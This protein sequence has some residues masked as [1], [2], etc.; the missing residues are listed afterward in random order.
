MIFKIKN[1]GNTCYFNT[2]L[3]AFLCL[4]SVREYIQGVNLIDDDKNDKKL[5]FALSDM[6][7]KY[8]KQTR[9]DVRKLYK[10]YVNTFDNINVNEPE[11]CN[12]CLLR[13][14]DIFMSENENNE[15]MKSMFYGK[16]REK[17]TYKCCNH[18]EYIDEP[19]V[20]LM[21]YKVNKDMDIPTCIKHRLI[22]ETIKNVKCDKCNNK[23]QL[24][25]N[26]K[27]IQLPIVLIL[28]IIIPTDGIVIH[29]TLLIGSH[30]YRLKYVNFYEHNHYYNM[31]LNDENRK[32]Y[33]INDDVIED[34]D[35]DISHLTSRKCQMI[36]FEK[37]I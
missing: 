24:K 13:L 12:E 7:N 9:F 20:S 25:K 34:R 3:Q 8:S 14:I 28:Y 30:E 35:Y 15:I 17:M 2:A 36:I 22:S 33:I 26:T 6:I 1:I 18:I 21:L 5:L 37:I 16:F 29:N 11:D 4:K 27:I 32:Y 31:V 19:F 23:T 10:I